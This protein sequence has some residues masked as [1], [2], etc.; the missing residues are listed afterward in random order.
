MVEGKKSNLLINI[1][2]QTLDAA[3][4]RDR[5]KQALSEPNISLVNLGLFVWY[6]DNIF[7]AMED[8]NSLAIAHMHRDFVE[9]VFVWLN[10][11]R[12]RVFVF[13]RLINVYGVKH[14]SISEFKKTIG[15]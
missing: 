2:N 3:F 12:L 13:G 7:N 10:G 9:K 14:Q 4:N 8:H 15:G 11:Q 1:D 6:D 5:I